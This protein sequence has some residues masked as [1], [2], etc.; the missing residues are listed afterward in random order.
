MEKVLLI[1][2][3]MTDQQL[4]GTHNRL[5]V[6]TNEKDRTPEDRGLAA[7]AL[8]VIEVEGKKRGIV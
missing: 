8:N 1:Y 6:V 5:V 7:T 3:R 4:I 2:G